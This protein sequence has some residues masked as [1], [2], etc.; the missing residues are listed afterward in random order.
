MQYTVNSVQEKDTTVH[1]LF[2]LQIL[3]V[4]VYTMYWQNNQYYLVHLSAQP[5]I[6]LQVTA[7]HANGLTKHAMVSLMSSCFFVHENVLYKLQCIV[8]TNLSVI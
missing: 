7:F 3:Q 1:V 5:G 2:F 8:S 6:K 4:I